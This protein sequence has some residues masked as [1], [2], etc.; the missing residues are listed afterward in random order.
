M[1][2]LIT[3]SLSLAVAALSIAVLTPP[4]AHAD[5][6]A[7]VAGSCV[8]TVF[9]TFSHPVTAVPAPNGMTFWGTG[10]CVESTQVLAT[11]TGFNGTLG[12]NSLNVPMSCEGGEMVG[13][14][15]FALSDP[16]FPDPINMETTMGVAAGTATMYVSLG[17]P[18]FVGVVELV[19]N[20]VDVAL[21]PVTGLTTT[22]WTATFTWEDPKV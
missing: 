21:C 18:A 4:A 14:T 17:F 6:R 7:V 2:R 15:N 22:T 13:F 10:T 16:F 5:Q 1:R 8:L 11:V 19:Q 3:R 9:G 12:P 20:P